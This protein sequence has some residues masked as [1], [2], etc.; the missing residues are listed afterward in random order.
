M[1]RL[2]RDWTRINTPSYGEATRNERA[3]STPKRSPPFSLRLNA[4]ERR[5]LEQDAGRHSMSSY[6]K[7]CLFDSDQPAKPAR[8]LA[9]VKDH[10]A[11]AQVLALLG[12]SR[13]SEHLGELADQAQHGVLPLDG[14]TEAGLRRACDDIQVMRRFL[15]AALGIRER[16]SET[17][18]CESCAS[19]FTR[20]V[21]D[22][23]ERRD[24]R[25]PEP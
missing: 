25:E 1:S 18:V 15:L 8:G 13:L 23:R 17:N 9:P 6:I 11:L 21:A 3:P 2:T 4:D 20:A 7:S 14:E 24:E 5:Q 16:D 19:A 22:T 12:S 10:E